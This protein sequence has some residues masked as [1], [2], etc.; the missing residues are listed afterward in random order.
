MKMQP[1]EPDG[2]FAAKSGSAPAVSLPDP[3]ALASALRSLSLRLERET[4]GLML[5]TG[6]PNDAQSF[7]LRCIALQERDKEQGKG[8]AVMERLVQFADERGLAITLTPSDVYG[9]NVPRL[10]QFY[11]RFGFV[12]LDAEQL[13]RYPQDRG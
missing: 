7:E 11:A 12:E 9:G 10:R 5:A 6:I 13:I 8:T 4:P 2:R 3:R 1:R